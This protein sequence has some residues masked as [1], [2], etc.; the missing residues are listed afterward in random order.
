MYVEVRI[1]SESLAFGPCL[2]SS[3]DRAAGFYPAC[4]EFDPLRGHSALRKAQRRQ[5]YHLHDM[6]HVLTNLGPNSRRGIREQPAVQDDPH[7]AH[8]A[9][10]PPELVMSGCG[11]SRYVMVEL[12]G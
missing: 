8:K 3:V 1:L 12:V 6:K 2:R 4:R 9:W 10:H 7:K 11:Y 5:A